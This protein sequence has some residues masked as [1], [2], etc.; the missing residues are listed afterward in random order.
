MSFPD[1][2]CPEPY[3]FG[4]DDEY[5]WFI[6]DIIGHWYNTDGNLEFEVQWSLGDTT[7][8]PADGCQELV[9]LDRYLKLQGA[10]DAPTGGSQNSSDC[11]GMWP[12]STEPSVG[13]GGGGPMDVMPSF[14]DGQYQNQAMLLLSTIVA[15]HTLQAQ[16][17][18]TMPW[19]APPPGLQQGHFQQYAPQP[20]YYYPQYPY[21]PSIL[22]PLP[23]PYW[24]QQQEQTQ[25]TSTS[26]GKGKWKATE[27][28]LLQECFDEQHLQLTT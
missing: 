1:Q 28:D 11:S 8:E 25:L 4:M 3:D 24:Q 9:A 22:L 5:E 10:R 16:T 13:S 14:E 21:V 12:M 17:M 19:P 23:I 18:A 26:T 27:Q 20:A 6:E 15:P 7:W 2:L